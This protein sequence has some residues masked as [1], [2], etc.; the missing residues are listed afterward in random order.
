VGLDGI[1]FAPGLYRDFVNRPEHKAKKTADRASYAWDRLIGQFTQ[2]ILDGTSIAVLGDPQ[3]AGTIEPALRTMAR[4][5]R[6]T[7]RALSQ[8]FLDTLQEA[9]RRR[10]DRFARIVLPNQ[11]FADPQ[12]GYVFMVLAYPTDID[13]EGGYQQYRRARAT[14]LGAHCHAAL[15]DNRNLKRMVGIAVDAS[16][17]VTGRTG[18]SEDLVAIEITEWTPEL[19]RHTEELRLTF[20]ILIPSRVQS[21]GFSMAKYPVLGEAP[22]SRQQ[23]RALEREA[24]K[25]RRAME[26]TAW[27]KKAPTKR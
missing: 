21:G 25:Q 17:E 8:A 7:R 11:Y 3:D 4:E 12:S 26:R 5:D 1:F 16:S 13:L 6:V 18:G 20:D 15:Y 14:M 10:Q 2:N 22:L 9:E 24:K 27:A 23:R 19:E